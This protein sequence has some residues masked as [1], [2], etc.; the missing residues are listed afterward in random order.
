M[1]ICFKGFVVGSSSFLFSASLMATRQL[2][3]LSLSA[4]VCFACDSGKKA[5]RCTVRSRRQ[6]WQSSDI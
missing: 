6:A 3:R 1:P 2:D 5:S 4:I